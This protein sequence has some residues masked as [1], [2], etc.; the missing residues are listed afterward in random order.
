MFGNL[1]VNKVHCLLNRREIAIIIS[2]PHPTIESRFKIMMVEF[3]TIVAQVSRLTQTP[4][5][6]QH[7]LDQI[8]RLVHMTDGQMHVKSTGA[9]MAS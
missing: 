7:S 9:R 5:H 6:D 8:T 1:F 3:R 2:L 4:N